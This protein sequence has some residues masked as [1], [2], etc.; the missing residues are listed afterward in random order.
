MLKH[1]SFITTDADRLMAFYLLLE[2]Q[3]TKDETHP[4][5]KLRRVVLQFEGGTLQFFQ[6]SDGI[7]PTQPANWME[8]IAFIV[9]DFDGIHDRLKQQGVVFSREITRSPSGKRMFFVLDPDGRQLEILE[10]SG[11]KILASVER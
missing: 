11:R 7:L 3:I 5:E 9:D 8:H 10:S 6:P 1:V 2:G 4:E